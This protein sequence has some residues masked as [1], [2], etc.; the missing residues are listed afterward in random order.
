MQNNKLNIAKVS[1][2]FFSLICCDFIKLKSKKV[3]IDIRRWLKKRFEKFKLLNKKIFSLK[4]IEKRNK[5]E[6][7]ILQAKNFNSIIRPR[8]SNGKVLKIENNWGETLSISVSKIRINIVAY[9]VIR[10]FF[11]VKTIN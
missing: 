3:N 11:W 7:I 1:P 10:E 2:K 9:N 6:S 5:L 8:T 4:L